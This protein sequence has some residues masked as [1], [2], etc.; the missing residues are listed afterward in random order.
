MEDDL[1]FHNAPRQNLQTWDR[2]KSIIAFGS[3][4]III[5][6]LLMAAFLV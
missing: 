1:E 2:L 6:L 4:A 3:I 5:T